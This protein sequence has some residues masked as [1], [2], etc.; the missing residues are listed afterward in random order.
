MEFAALAAQSLGEAA[1][2]ILQ[3]KQIAYL[4]GG[5]LLG[6]SVGVFPGLGGIA[7]LALVIPFLYGVEPISGLALMVGLVAVIPTSDTFSSV[8]LGIPGSSSSQATVLDGFPLSKQGRAAQALSAAFV[9][10]LFGG[11]FGATILTFFIVLARPIILLFGLPELLLLTILG[12]S[13]VGVLSGRSFA[14]GFAAV[15]LGMLVGA[16]GF[17]PATGSPR[18]SF[19]QWY[20]EDGF[21]LVVVSLGIFAIPEIISLLRQDRAISRDSTLGA[22]WMDGLRSWWQNKWLS[23]RC[24]FIGVVVGIIPGLGGNVVDWIAYGHT[25]QSTRDRERF[26]SGDIRGVIGPESSNNS[27]EGGGLVPTLLF[28]IP[29]SGSMAVFIGGLILLG[30]EPGPQMISNDLPLTYTIVWSLALANVIGAGLCIGLSGGI[31]RMTTV[32]FPLLAPFLLT[33]IAFAAFQS[34]QSLWDLVALFGFG[35]LG[36]LLRRFAWSR[37][38][39]LIGFVLADQAEVYTYQLIQ[40]AGVR[41]TEGLTDGLAYVFSPTAIILLVLIIGS[42]IAASRFSPHKEKPEAPTP[43]TGRP[44]QLFAGA[45]VAFAAFALFSLSGINQ[46]IDKAFPIVAASIALIGGAA[47][48]LQMYLRRDRLSHAVYA[49]IEQA[50]D[51]VALPRGL[52]LTFG[53]LAGLLIL[54]SVVGFI[55]AMATFFVVFLRIRA[56]ASWRMTIGATVLGL[57]GILIL[58]AALNREF[59]G[60]ILQS[61]IELPWPLSGI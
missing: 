60:G 5:V 25:V 54:T 52:L 4:I 30:H 21:Q 43:A 12:F 13:M 24:A 35:L 53:W 27:K 32:R 3:P 61:L 2:L 36:I 57:G 15:G 22:G 46:T 34:R 48:L 39:F 20:L 44:Q 11:L 19:G 9:S 38:A 41:F 58:A 28:G 59:P 33:M 31:A 51:D 29:G 17:A 56:Q 45:L 23:F 18:L 42:L 8:L 10:S 47:A 6:L 40:I 14:K 49:D 55:L 37:P 1:H 16:I 50:G 26:G 7:G